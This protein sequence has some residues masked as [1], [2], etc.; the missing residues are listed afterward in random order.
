[1]KKNMVQLRQLKINRF[2]EILK[3]FASLD[4]DSSGAEKCPLCPE[5]LLSK[6][7][8]T[9][10]LQCIKQLDGDEKEYQL[11]A[12]AK[13]AENLGKGQSQDYNFIAGGQ[14]PSGADCRRV[15]AQH[16][17]HRWHPNVSCP[18]CQEMFAP[19]EIDAHLTLCL[20]SAPSK[21]PFAVT[22][23]APKEDTKLIVTNQQISVLAKSVLEKST[24]SPDI[25]LLDLLDTFRSLGLTKSTMEERLKQ[26]S[27]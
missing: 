25:S 2:F 5:K 9:H 19:Y 10:V 24:S 27:T 16:F 18:L 26:A 7:F 20:S 21:S 8:E 1:M 17:I 22:P 12:D 3:G 4:F 14:C 13:L 23:S 15:D 6:D 11:K